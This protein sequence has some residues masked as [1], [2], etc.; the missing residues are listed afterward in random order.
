MKGILLRGALVLGA[1][2]LALAPQ[3]ALSG[4][5]NPL[6][7]LTSTCLFRCNGFG[8]DSC[9]VETFPISVSSDTCIV[10]PDPVS[11]LTWQG[12]GTAQTVDGDRPMAIATATAV[13]EEDPGSGAASGG[14]F[15][16]IATLDYFVRIEQTHLP[17]FMPSVIHLTA[18]ARYAHSGSSNCGSVGQVT[19]LRGNTLLLRW[20]PN[21]ASPPTFTLDLSL[22]VGTLLYVL[23]SATA[24]PFS[25]PG[26][27]VSN[28]TATTDPLFTFDQAA[29][30]AEWGGASFPLEDY[31]VI[32]SSADGGG[33]GGSA[34]APAPADGCHVAAKA[35]LSV[36]EKKAGKEKLSVAL[37]R[38]EA[39]TGPADL[40]DPVSGA[41]RY[42]LCIYDAAGQLA[43]GLA[44]D[45]AGEL[46]GAKQKPCW[47]AKGA[48]GYAYKDPDA[49]A[50]GVRK[51][52]AVAGPEG[53]GKLQ[54]QAGNN[55][56]RSQDALPTGIAAALEAASSATLQLVANDG[57]C[58]EA[59]LSAV[60]KND[61]ETFK[62]RAR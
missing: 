50:G 1:W 7:S 8:F 16:A 44:V 52:K 21:T 42:D 36:V 53:K 6:P 39:A 19:I 17:P 45:R 28:C 48:S 2:G 58:F 22:P 11:G 37:K 33:S 43:G 55:A 51:M 32:R 3:P 29:F 4:A 46:C 54:L 38:V 59:A 60:K 13:S 31:F 15:D 49:S 12:F 9:E 56:K 34:C 26:V 10:G 20:Q 25:G 41:T 35:K 40:G 14:Y 57:A 24:T 47:K 30:D 27:L 62:A 61:A 23:V 5:L 18:E